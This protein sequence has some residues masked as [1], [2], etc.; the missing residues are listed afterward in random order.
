[1]H[2]KPRAKAR[3]LLVDDDEVICR[4]LERSLR[5]QQQFEIH[6]VRDSYAATT[7]FETQGPFDILLTDLQLL[8]VGGGVEL[9][10]RLVERKP[11]LRVIFMSGDFPRGF[12]SAHRT[13][14]KPFE[15]DQLVRVFEE[16][17]LASHG[18]IE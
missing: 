9:A 18:K 6:T 3:V 10:Q 16:A 1:M 2:G 4:S 11:D 14:E 13:L 8:N 17:L 12:T 15:R 5:N 7:A